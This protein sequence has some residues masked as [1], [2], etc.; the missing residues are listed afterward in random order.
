MQ[1]DVETAFLNETV[2]SE[3]Y[4]KQPMGYEDCTDRVCKLE[5]ALY[6][7]RESPR[8][9]Y[10]CF[11]SYL[12][13]LG[14]KKSESDYC[15]YM[16]SDQDDRIYVIMFVDDLL[17]CGKNE[18]K[19]EDIKSKLSNKF[20]MKDLGEVKTYLGINIEYDCKT[21]SEHK[22]T[23]DQREYIESLARKYN[24]EEA[25]LYCT[26][27]EQN[28]KVEPAQSVCNDIKFRNLIGALLYISTGTKPDVS[29]S[30]NYLSRFQN[31]YN[32]THYKYALRILKYLY[33]TK[34]LKLVYKR[35]VNAEIIDCF[36]DADWAGDE[37]DRKST[38]GYIIRVYGN[39]IYWKSKKQGSVTK[40]STAAEYVALSES[41]SEL[42]VII[43]LLKEFNV[44]IKKPINVYEDNSGAITI[45]KF[46]NFTKN[47][48]YIEVHY[49]F[50]HECYEKG[51][52]DIVKVDSE[53]NIA[54]ILTK[55]LGKN[56][57]ERFRT[58]LNLV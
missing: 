38:T 11:D 22:L 41:I 54:D 30:V 48:K 36:V 31:H 5:K 26:P 2:K 8:A 58:I 21:Q 52:I 43:N 50:V 55:S 28:L 17:I 56:K 32:E 19:L 27:M 34:D 14:F 12:R 13:N 39:V 6:G 45:A 46:G 37:L 40:S 25:K 15:L 18:K 23:L 4:V 33:L 7:L 29:Y 53:N 3:I 24:I 44:K 20:A 1:M 57:F 35:N 47:S 42:K 10:E 51:I 9:W 49:H 16:M